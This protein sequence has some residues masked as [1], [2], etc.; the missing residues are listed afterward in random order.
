M[1]ATFSAALLRARASRRAWLTRLA[2]LAILL[3]AGYLRGLSLRDWDA[4]TGQHP[5]ERFFTNVASTVRLP[6]SAAEFIDS[7]RSPLN[8][9]SYHDFGLYVYG[10][11][12]IS[13]TRLT[14][15]WLTP[16][17]LLPE[18]VPTIVGQPQRGLDPAAPN[19]LRTNFGP[20]VANPERA[21]PRSDLLIELFNPDRVNLTGY[22]EIVKVGRSLA[23]LFDLGSVLLIFATARRLF[24]T[25]TALLAAALSA[26]TVMQIQQSHFFVD[27]VFSTFFALLTLYA[28]V[29]TTQVPGWG[30]YALIGISVG[31]AM[32]NRITMATLG[33]LA[34]AA[35]LPIALRAVNGD[36]TRWAA[37][38]L[39]HEL[40]RLVLAGVLALAV[41]RTLAPDAFVGSSAAEQPITA[42]HDAAGRLEVLQGAGWFDIRLDERFVDDLTTVQALVSG[43]YDFPPSQQWVGRTDYLF[44]WRNLVLF[45]MGPALGLAAW[46][47]WLLIGARGAAQL[48]QAL[49]GAPL[50]RRRA[51]LWLL[52]L[53]VA[54]YFGW[55][56]GQFAITMRYLLPIYGALIIPAAWLL[57]TLPRW[58]CRR[59]PLQRFAALQRT[60]TAV[61]RWLPLTVLLL[62]A[63]WAYAFTRIYTVPH[64]R[65]QAAEWLV[66]HSEPGSAVLWEV[67][68]D[69][70]PLQTT[71]ASWGIGY[72]GI[73][74][75]PYSEDDPQ[76][77]LAEGGLLD[78][79]D[80]VDYITLTSNRVYDSTSRLR[81]R[82]PALMR[83]YEGLFSGRLGFELVADVT[84]YPR[85]FGI[86]IPDQIAEEAFSV[87][88]H[89]RVLIFHKT[90]TYSREAA[91]ELLTADVNWG[92][93]YKSPVQVADRNATALRF[94][95]SVWPQV[96]AAGDWWATLGNSFWAPLWWFIWLEVL[97]IA[98]LVLIARP[99]RRLP[100]AGFSLA[101]VLGLVLVSY[102]AWL[103]GSFKLAPFS[104][105]TLQL[106]A[107]TLTAS[108]ALVGW[109]QRAALRELWL[110]RRTAWLRLE[111]IWI[112]F[113][114]LGLLLRWFNP[115]LWH[116]A[117]G[118][119]KP[120]DLA[121]LNAVLRA[122]SFPPADPWHA[123]GYVNYYYFGFVLVGALVQLSGVA[124]AVGYN[125]AVAT[126]FGLT[127]AAAAGLVFNLLAPRRTAAG[128]RL[129]A[130]SAAAGLA[131]ALVLL[132]GNLAQPL[133]LLS[134]YAQE[135][136]ARGR[137]EWAF[138][139]ATRL[140]AGTVNEFPFFSFLFGDLHAHLL[141]MPLGLTL[142][143]LALTIRRLPFA[144]LPWILSTLLL[145]VIRATNSWD[146]PTYGAL[147]TLIA[148]TAISEGQRARGLRWAAAGV[149]ATAAGLPLLLSNVAILP[150]LQH[151]ASSSDGATLWLGPG[152]SLLEQLFRAERTTTQQL[153]AMHG[154]WLAATAAVV[155]FDSLRSL[156]RLSGPGALPR[157]LWL[158]LLLRHTAGWL[159]FAAVCWWNL[160][161]LLPLAVLLS[162]VLSR[163][164]D[165]APGTTARR[166]SLLLFSAALGLLLL[167]ELVTIRGDVGRMNTVFKFGL[168][169][170]IWFAIGTAAALPGMAVLLRRLPAQLQTAGL[171]TAGLLAALLLT[172]PLTATP[173]RWADR[174]NAAAPTGLDGQA[175]MAWITAERNGA[176]FALNDD[177][178]GI[179]WLRRN[180]RGTPVIVEAHAPSYQWAGRISAATGLP[181]LLGWEWHQIQ[182]RSAVG[183][184]PAIRNRQR[185][186]AEIYGGAAAEQVL[187]HLQ[188][189]DVRYVYLGAYEQVRYPAAWALFEEMSAAG[190]LQPV[191]RYG[192]V[193]IYEVVQR[194]TPTMLTDD[195]PL[196]VP[197]VRTL[198]FFGLSESVN[199]LPAVSRMP[200]APLLQSDVPA[201]I[202]WTLLLVLL[203]MAGALP[204]RLVF[205]VHGLGWARMLG[206]LLF[207]WLVWLPVSLGLWRFD[208][209]AL[210]FSGGVLALGGWWGYRRLQQTGGGQWRQA[211]R[212][213]RGAELAFVLG[214][215]LML[216]LRAANPD[217][218]HPIWGG[219]KPMEQ[220]FLNALL[221]TP[222]L[223]PPDP[224]LSDGRINY[225]YYGFMLFAVPL[226]LSGIDPAIGYNLA[227]AT[228]AGLLSS[229]A[230]QL[231][232]SVG[233]RRSSGVIAVVLTVVA[234]N[235][236][237]ALQH[238]WSRGWSVLPALWQAGP[239]QAGALLGD[240]FVGPSR[241]IGGTI[242]EFP[243]FSLLY[244]DLHPHVIALPIFLLAAALAWR[245][246][247]QAARPQLAAAALVLGTAAVTNSWDAPTILLLFGLAVTARAWRAAG[248][249]WRQLPAAI[250]RGGL[251]AGLL[252]LGGLAAYAPFFDFF[253]AMVGGVGLV[254]WEA[255]GLRDWLIVGGLA[256]LV[257][258][259]AVGL[260]LQRGPRTEL[261]IWAAAAV[262]TGL[263][264]VIWPVAALRALLLLLGLA[265]LRLLLRQPAAGARWTALVWFGT[266]LAVTLGTEVVYIRDHL[267]GGDFYRMNSV[268]KFG[269]QAWLLNAA[270]AAVWLP[271]LWQRLTPLW[272][273][274]L[275]AL[276][277]LPTAAVLSYLPLAVPSRIDTRIATNAGVTLDGMAFYDGGRFS[278]DCG[279]FGG[280]E[281]AG[282]IVEIDLSGDGQ[283][284]DWLNANLRGMP[285][286]VQS[287]LWFYRA[288]GIRVAAAT[289]LPTVISALHAN[290]QHDPARTARRDRDVEAL[291]R[292]DDIEQALRV[293]ARYDVRFVYVGAIE[294]AFYP[295]GVA[296]FAQ[297]APYLQ[298]VYDEAGVQIYAVRD[299]PAAYREI[300]P[301][302]EREPYV[303]P[304]LGEPSETQALDAGSAFAVAQALRAAGDL[305]AAAEVLEPAAV[306]TPQDVG[307]QHLLGDILLE[308]GAY[309]GAERAYRQ[310]VLTAPTAD[311]YTKLGGGLVVMERWAAAEQAL[312][313]AL[314]INPQ[315][316]DA[317]WFRALTAEQRGDLPAAIADL[318]RVVELAPQ[319]LYREPAQQL[320]L[321]LAQR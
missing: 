149:S 126:F 214:Y 9:R 237:A 82:Y 203:S 301:E 270:A 107:L 118:G 115:D 96:T 221:R 168:Q 179:E 211:L 189:Y 256:P 121:L 86:S 177:L 231:G 26:L 167:V 312:A 62:T 292:S 219:E 123:G 114:L 133:M 164:L 183:A 245:L 129:W 229:S 182:Q 199:R 128:G 261:L 240:W 216:T 105:L 195:R 147:F 202:G 60:T 78:Q 201:V 272:R 25:R 35:A 92:E 56:G 274:A 163:L 24:G 258:I 125:L 44:P 175:Y 65:V 250:V 134:G 64:S 283:A 172:Y 269:M 228:V 119:E 89:P 165:G 59:Q 192:Q 161:A 302:R 264:G 22:G 37:R 137:N 263:V 156:R 131:P 275:A 224:F 90:A 104:P 124:P 236:A 27:P 291:Y 108:A 13:L 52:W 169:S 226:R 102:A 213:A 215:G 29:R 222:T 279:V 42:A 318:Q 84:S 12:P 319:G 45:G 46:A 154:L 20:P 254:R 204:A 116:P 206:W 81:M 260:Q 36:R 31:L 173:A 5:D 139:D 225:Y 209:P 255:T 87:Y 57:R 16:A 320:L 97:T 72:T 38:V 63:G 234:G 210:L 106:T 257:L 280:C 68:D 166:L 2:L 252:L 19:D 74:S 284:I 304:V 150:F 122:G 208:G 266:A 232:R 100:D 271:L 160:P 117:R 61:L 8:P 23:L 288:Y 88:D 40:P 176:E 295:R 277:L 66:E 138:W 153:V 33:L 220:G 296:K 157:D 3:T 186:I 98:L 233:G 293:L 77:Y 110:E 278:Y 70:L 151:F 135:Q 54:F 181:T 43:E 39:Q 180:A 80:Q 49:N 276:L 7:A 305:A 58:W 242:N 273:P 297:M 294:H 303:S 142:L 28:G 212:S 306:L 207:S 21:L 50:R 191:L 93:V 18:Q 51:G 185:V 300:L 30:N 290:E 144:W 136:I 265:V 317:Y 95:D 307:L 194:G 76:K 285:I 159:L 11:F 268:F 287:N 238:G 267:D 140:I 146:Y 247:R 85:I 205:G 243:A 289:G 321:E 48:W 170:W 315:Q 91:E 239:A 158:P 79:L 152:N 223:P 83:Y 47:A 155:L 253:T 313:A 69:P 67:W 143:A 218:W 6:G 148:A 94:T 112:G 174:W 248:A 298:A 101:R 178:A 282:G 73:R 145:G 55:Q 109:R 316:A 127:A 309:D 193:R 244:A 187:Q 251:T 103:L 200:W 162:V 281:Q 41:F 10:P 299:I 230:Y 71:A 259:A 197:T 111:L 310:A 99:L 53:W 15:A 171:A 141:V 14:A 120:M 190:T 32:T 188:D 184:E 249:G 314:Q 311:N 235:F 17:E 246:E 4:G 1:H 132:S 241:V 198:P 75:E 262:L 308:L 130:A 227:L 113:V 196:V 34:V 286:V 217:L